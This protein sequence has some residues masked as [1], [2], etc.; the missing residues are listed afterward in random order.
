MRLT[1]IKLSGFK[2]FVET[3]D[4]AIPSNLVGVVGP[5][6][7]G[8][9]NIIDAV[10]WVLGESKASELRGESMQDVI[11]N[12][13]T[14][15]KPAGRCSV[16]LVFD[17]ADGRLQGQWSSYT[18]ISIKRVL[19]RDGSSSY[20]INNQN[21]RRKDVYDVF[22][23]TG[24]GSR[25]Y[26][27]IGQGMINR[28]IEAKPEEMRVY[29]EE[30]AGVSRYKERRRETENRLSDT[31]ENLQRVEDIES[32]LDKQIDK[33]N[34]QSEVAS[35]YNLLTS[36]AQKMEHVFWFLKEANA[37]S[38]QVF[39][40]EKLA[41]SSTE[42]EKLMSNIQNIELEV[43]NKRLAYQSI[44]DSLREVQGEFY[45]ANNT[46]T[47]LE[48]ESK[49][50]TDAKVRLNDQNKQI[51]EKLKQWNDQVSFLESELNKISQEIISKKDLVEEKKKSEISLSAGLPEL[52]SI[53]HK[54]SKSKDVQRSEIGKQE[55]KIAIIRQ[56]IQD[57]DRNKSRL[58]SK[59]ESLKKEKTNLEIP[60]SDGSVQLEEQINS[61]KT[62]YKKFETEYF[63]LEESLASAATKVNDT[64]TQA[65]EDLKVYS[66]NSAKLQAL[67]NLQNEIQSKGALEA[68][69]R[70]NNLSN[71][72]RLWQDLHIEPGWEVALESVL[73]ERLVGVEVENL[74]DV[75]QYLASKPPARFSFYKKCKEFTEIKNNNFVSL[76]SKLKVYDQDL[77][78][79]LSRWLD[80][81]YVI[82]NLDLFDAEILKLNVGE[83]LVSKNGH[84]VDP[85]GVLLYAPENE[86]AG[87]L[88]RQQ[89]IENLEKLVKALK[90]QSDQSH[91][92]LEEYL[93]ESKKFQNLLN[94]SRTELTKLTNQIHGL[95][96]NL[97]TQKSK[98]EQALMMNERLDRELNEAQTQINEVEKS[99]VSHESNLE[100]DK[101]V[102][103]K[104]KDKFRELQNESAQKYDEYNVLMK[105]VQTVRSEIREANLIISSLETRKTELER[106]KGIATKQ[107]ESLTIEK[108][109]LNNDL[110]GFDEGA[111]ESALQEALGLREQKSKHL[112]EIKISLDNVAF[113][114]KATDE[115][116]LRISHQIDPLRETITKL[117]LSEQAARIQAQQFSE[118]L[119]EA[120]VDRAQL[121]NELTELSAE[122][123]K[124]TWLQAQI[125]NRHKQIEALG[126]VNLAAL[127]E[128]EQAKERKLFLVKQIDDLQEAI[129]TLEEAINKID[130]ETRELLSDTFEQA[131][132]HFADMFPKLFG[133]GEAKLRMIGDQILSSGIEVMAHPP[134][135]RNTSIHLLSG[136]EKALTA[137]ALVFAL[138]KL[139]PAPF[140]LLD[141]VD[142]P[143]D[144]ANT[145]RYADLVSE[146]SKD[147][148]FV[149]ISHNKI[150]MQMAHQLI[151]VTQQEQGVSRIVAVDIDSAVKLVDS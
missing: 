77:K 72:K 48:A 106:N 137:I 148:Q 2:S 101:Q 75:K 53:A 68:W 96:I 73:R 25:G 86:Q 29:L 66:Q 67:K 59:L 33:L 122:W 129:D 76:F 140:C 149:F 141:E 90:L 104:L 18:E 78:N 92:K 15:R 4:I 102:L 131:N 124:V 103:T 24:L 13:S 55:Q 9:S 147:I 144:D 91:E 34:V 139:N 6:G 136:G 7:C 14:N 80:G 10:R 99:L 22:L 120:Q 46:V 87:I 145:E 84:I 20:F 74:D 146:M 5:N 28:I 16:E 114:L 26:A 79:S 3:T 49:H 110:L 37:L 63:D 119:E 115:N 82:E 47:K 19:T 12:G 125:G 65:D 41:S 142:A 105:K 8:K 126:A 38:E 54:S 62:K 43:E 50:L 81:V 151:G 27:I 21:V 135:K 117:Q 130:A 128:L 138:F 69:L 64:R 123:G 112:N 113:E 60:Q 93:G 132:S 39:I 127:E 45:E 143:L 52:E 94:E 61:L 88:A 70:K 109:R 150:A 31:H 118:K 1:H 97:N 100:N 83:S 44:S 32:E 85:T 23:G 36:E 51:E 111:C 121:K 71:S 95:E 11:F 116:R 89:E 40:K 134:G 57:L 56:K 107:I 133:G 58:S 42:L 30:V 108:E 98:L 35:K 17:N